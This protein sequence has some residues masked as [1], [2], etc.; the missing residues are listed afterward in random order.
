MRAPLRVSA[1]LNYLGGG[2]LLSG[3]A[4]GGEARVLSGV[5]LH[6]SKRQ[7]RPSLD[8]PY[9]C[10]DHIYPKTSSPFAN[11]STHPPIP[12]LTLYV[13]QVCTYTCMYLSMHICTCVS[14]CMYVCMY[15]YIYYIYRLPS[16]G[17]HTHPHTHTHTHTHTHMHIYMCIKNI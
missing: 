14:S 5:A 6:A 17:N 9:L 11:P 10:K 15:V 12:Q 4:L 1:V 13:Y 7:S 8:L 3:V 16:R 2:R